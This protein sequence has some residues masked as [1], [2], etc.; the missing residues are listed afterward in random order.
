MHYA[1]H[2]LSMTLDTQ[3]SGAVGAVLII[4][5]EITE[6]DVAAYGRARHVYSLDRC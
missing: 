6:M 2:I 3:A 5:V 1:R 4:D